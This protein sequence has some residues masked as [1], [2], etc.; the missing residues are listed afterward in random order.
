M[1]TKLK[2]KGKKTPDIM[3]VEKTILTWLTNNE[4]LN[5]IS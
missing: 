1:I 3:V 2:V 4:F 5:Y